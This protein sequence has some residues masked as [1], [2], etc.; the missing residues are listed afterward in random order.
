MLQNSQWFYYLQLTGHIFI[1]HFIKQSNCNS[2]W[3]IVNVSKCY[4]TINNKL[5]W[6]RF[7]L[8]CLT[9]LST[10][11]QFTLVAETWIPVKKTTDLSQVTDKLY[12]IMLYRV[13]LAINRV[14]THNFSSN[15]SLINLTIIR[16]RPRW[17]CN[18]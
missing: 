9:P 4:T 10:I 13:H 17:P 12:H 11:F 16:S 7:G 18:P 1:L 14:R 5:V 8:W 15:R 3:Y 6:F 2:I